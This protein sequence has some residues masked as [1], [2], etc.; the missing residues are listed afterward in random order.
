M[1]WHTPI[2]QGGT[3]ISPKAGYAPDEYYALKEE[4]RSPKVLVCPADAETIVAPDWD[5]FILDP[6]YGPNSVSYTLGLHTFADRP[7]T[8]L[9]ADRNIRDNGG[10]ASCTPTGI[11]DAWRIIPGD[12]NVGWTSTI[13][14]NTGNV[15]LNDGTVLFTDSTSLRNVLAADPATGDGAL[16]ILRNR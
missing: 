10:P 8:L 14:G 13:H 11:N 12:P 5:T 6:N 3:F 2:D 16:H 7:L 9:A 15:L 4:L 1:P